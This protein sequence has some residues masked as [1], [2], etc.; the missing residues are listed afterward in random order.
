MGLKHGRVL[1][2]VEE[3]YFGDAELQ[4]AYFGDA[5]GALMKEALPRQFPSPPST[6]IPT[7][8]NRQ[9]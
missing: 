4:L 2:G 6:I 1:Q 5:P 7:A 9:R 8:H 3:D